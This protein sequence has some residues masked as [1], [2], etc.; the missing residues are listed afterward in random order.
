MTAER[1]TVALVA[2]RAGV[3]VASVSRVL[4]G[5][6]AGAATREK[7]E[8]AAAELGY[9]PNVFARSLKVR[10][11]QQLALA[12]AD[13]GNP[14]YVE[15]MRA[16][17]DEARG[18]GYR[19]LVSSTGG[20]SDDTLA[21]LDSLSSG[22][23]DGLLLSPVRVDDTLVEALRR[24]SFP[25]VVIGTI[26]RSVPLDN[27]RANSAGGV[28]L[29]LEHLHARGR[30]R[31]AFLNGPSDTVPGSARRRAFERTART[32]GLDPAP[33]LRIEAGDFTLGEG[34]KAAEILLE[35]T[36]PDAV[37]GGNDLLAIATMQVLTERGLRIPDD[38][39]VVGMDDTEL[40]G[41]TS[42]ALTSV[43]LGAHERGRTAARLLLARLT[44]PAR[45]VQRVAVQPTLTVRDSS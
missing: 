4:N 39:A 8:R 24:V 15:M 38:V 10:R 26:P 13:V 36:L 7:V 3:S 41:V 19:L 32:L 18:S 9:R 35:R 5:L 37:L 45:E 23:A 20:R 43:D 44:D 25:A 29:A 22:Y 40:A 16:I 34:R 21:L 17:E 2:Q 42:P 12:V 27:V 30:R 33:E 6:P 14:V 1:P 11:S 28:R 31:I